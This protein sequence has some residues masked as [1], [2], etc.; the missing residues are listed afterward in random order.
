MTRMWY[1]PEALAAM[2]QS[3]AAITWVTSTAPSQ[4]PT[5]M[6]ISV[7]PGAMPRERSSVRS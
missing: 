4:A 1:W 6:G 2:T 5:L 7:A 3:M